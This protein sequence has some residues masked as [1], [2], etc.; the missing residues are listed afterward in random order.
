MRTDH[1][2]GT[3]SERERG[4]VCL[5]IDVHYQTLDATFRAHVGRVLSAGA[6]RADVRAALRF[7]AL[8]G[9]TRAWRGWQA[10]NAYFA[11]LD[12]AA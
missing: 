4:L 11:E 10:L 7:N 2:P 8:F 12:A 1:G 9:A 6:T 5:S 3:L